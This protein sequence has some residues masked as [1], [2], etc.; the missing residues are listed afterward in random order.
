MA[1]IFVIDGLDGC[2]KATQTKMLVDRLRAEGKNVVQ[3]SFPNYDSDSSAAVKMYLHGEISNNLDD[4][5]PYA[6]ATFYAVDRY[7]QYV[8]E[9]KKYIDEDDDTIILLDR[10]LSANIIH[11]A[12]KFDTGEEKHKFI[13]WCYEYECELLGLPKETYTLV[14]LINPKASQNLLLKR[15]NN[16]E[17][18]KDIHESNLEYLEKCY[19]E[20]FESVGYINNNNISNWGTMLCNDENS[21]VY[22]KEHIH[23]MVYGLAKEKLN[24]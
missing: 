15:Y 19:S 20:L 10:Y 16:D 1:K 12:S 17:N 2:G 5:N 14:L 13:K 6:C 8:K 21:D 22:S 24:L 4:L 23:E 18:R 9:M 3:F 7:I 11:Q